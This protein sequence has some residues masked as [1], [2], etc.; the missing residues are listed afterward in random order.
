M[1][2]RQ[3]DV[4]E[5]FSSQRKTIYNI[6]TIEITALKRTGITYHV[7]VWMIISAYESERFP[8]RI[9]PCLKFRRT[10]FDDSKTTP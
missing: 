7:R 9:G 2:A 8:L 5:V 10:P 1:D 6:F 4:S 3:S